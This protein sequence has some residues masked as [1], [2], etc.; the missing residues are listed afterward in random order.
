MVVGLLRAMDRGIKLYIVV[1]VG[2]VVWTGQTSEEREREREGER[3]R[4]GER[5]ERERVCQREMTVK[6]RVAREPNQTIDG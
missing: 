5:E 2:T 6:P 1:M 3:G 4:E